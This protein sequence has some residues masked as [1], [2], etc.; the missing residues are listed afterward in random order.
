MNDRRYRS[1]PL[2]WATMLLATCLLLVLFERVLW[3]VVPF[4]FALIAYYLMLPLQRRLVLRGVSHDSAA[5]IVSLGLLGVLALAMLFSAPTLATQLSALQTGGGR[6]LEGGL[7]FVGDT[8]AWLETNFAFVARARLGE[9]AMAGI[10]DFVEHFAA[11]YLPG[12]ALTAAA[13]FPSLLLIPFLTFFMLRDGWRFKRFLSAAVPNAFFER[14]LYLLDQVDR[15]ARGYFQGLIK[16]T[17]L[18]ALC[19]AAGLWAIGVSSPLLLGVVT[20]ILAWVPYVGSIAGCLLVVLVAAT[21][22]PGSPSLAYAAIALFVAVRLLDDFVFMP[23]TIGK[24]LNMHPLLTVLMIFV[25]G[26]VAGVAGLVL[27][28][29][30][31]GI[32]MVVGETLGA[33]LSD[34]RLRARH[35]FARS[36]LQRQVT[37]DLPP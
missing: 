15:T 32:V 22:H 10:G 25:G 17:V 7:R 18:D 1:G 35:R 26:A 5:V 34:P 6:Y 28:L 29:P 33:V 37:R 23:A 30:L 2:A 20:A 21:D 19:L 8:L 36:L 24:S 12:A 13:W 11:R 14:T 31:L 3:L 16:L 27:V 4:L 9:T